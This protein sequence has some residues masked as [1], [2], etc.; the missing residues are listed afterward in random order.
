MDD[1]DLPNVC[2]CLHPPAPGQLSSQ[3]FQGPHWRLH[4][5]S[6]CH[7]RY[8][9]PSPRQRPTCP[10]VA[11]GLCR[12]TA[13]PPLSQW[14]PGKAGASLDCRQERGLQGSALLSHTL[15][16][17][18]WL[19]PTLTLASDSEWDWGWGSAL[20][21]PHHSLPENTSGYPGHTLPVTRS[22]SAPARRRRALPDQRYGGKHPL[23]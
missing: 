8:Q 4:W 6:Q 14:E 10:Q 5:F 13:V 9:G 1:L 15:L 18:P 17:S 16:T 19:A 22:L 12:N 23:S 7:L 21:I 11:G 2:Q 20:S 3:S